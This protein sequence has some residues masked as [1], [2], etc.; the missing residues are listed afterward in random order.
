MYIDPE[1]GNLWAIDLTICDPTI[2]LDLTRNI[3][4]DTSVSNHFRIMHEN[5]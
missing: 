5:I 1:N 4:E 2:Y 3:H